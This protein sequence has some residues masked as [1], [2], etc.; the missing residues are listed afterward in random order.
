[1]ES[2]PEERNKQ[3]LAKLESTTGENEESCREL[4]QNSQW[5]YDIAFTRWY[6]SL[7]LFQVIKWHAWKIISMAFYYYGNTSQTNDSNQSPHSKFIS[8]FESNYGRQHPRMIEGSFSTALNRAKNEFKLLIV[9]LHCSINPNTDQ[10][11]REIL[12]NNLITEFFDEHFLFWTG[13]ISDKDGYWV[14]N[15]LQ[16]SGYP[17]LAV[18]RQNLV[19]GFTPVYQIDKIITCEEL[20]EQL[21]SILEAHEP[22]L[23]NQRIEQEERT[24]DRL[25]RE[26]QERE[27]QQSLLEDQ[28][29]EKRIREER[30]RIEEKQREEAYQR[31]EEERKKQDKIKRQ[32]ELLNKLPPEPSAGEGVTQLIFRLSDGSRLQRRFYRTDKLQLVYDFIDSKNIEQNDYDLVT[33]FPLRKF[34][35]K[36]KTLAELDLY[37]QASLFIS[38][39]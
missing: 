9:Y 18:V 5:N 34:D 2:T 3:L 35:D 7:S 33:N 36:T 13:D 29:K 17:F 23:T 31:Q 16:A 19:G 21:T 24:R 4:L 27:F 8:Q 15:T 22:I 1:M 12:C 26:E 38:S 11:C 39:K 20:M 30:Q 14:S 10:F 25:L 32:E 6:S 28:E 37:P